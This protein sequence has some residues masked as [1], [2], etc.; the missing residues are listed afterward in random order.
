MCVWGGWAERSSHQF[1][2]PLLSL[3]RGEIVTKI[4]SSAARMSMRAL[5]GG[6]GRKK[7][8]KE[9]KRGSFQ[10]KRMEG[11]T[12]IEHISKSFSQDVKV[13]KRRLTVDT[14]S[15]KMKKKKVGLPSH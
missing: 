4:G 1:P 6:R 11:V 13:R 8:K 15:P 7:E 3:A 10:E 12:K 9:K 2:V 14:E 5:P